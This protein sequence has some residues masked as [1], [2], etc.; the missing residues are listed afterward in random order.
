MLKLS[1]PLRSV[2]MSTALVSVMALTSA[3]SSEPGYD[4]SGRWNNDQHQLDTGSDRSTRDTSGRLRAGSHGYSDWNNTK[5]FDDNRDYRSNR[6]WDN[7]DRSNYAQEREERVEARISDLHNRLAITPDQEG[8][9]NE[10]ANIMRSNEAATRQAMRS[11]NENKGD[12]NAI[13]DLRSYERIA[14]THANGLRTLIP[15]FENLY[16]ALS[17]DQRRTADTIFDRYRGEWKK[18][19]RSKK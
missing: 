3:C 1:S 9:W 2:L 14:S 13:E 8:L 10:V 5:R 15:S 4:A 16:D 17:A 12:M 18:H 11:R 6:S 19:P 7:T